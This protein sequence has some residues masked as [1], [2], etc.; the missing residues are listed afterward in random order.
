L[1]REQ[2]LDSIHVL[3]ALVDQPLA[4]T[5]SATRVLALDRGHLNHLTGSPVAAA[6]CHQRPQ[7]HGRIQPV[8]FRA[9]CPAIDLKA[10]RI[11]HPAGDPLG[12]QATL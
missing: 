11:H 9:S 10:P 12:S 2:T 6:P 4:L 8:G 3:H 1:S 7:Q 5:G